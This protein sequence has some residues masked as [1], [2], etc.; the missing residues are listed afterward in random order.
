MTAK[1][2]ELF[3]EYNF[4][5]RYRDIFYEIATG[6][7]NQEI[8]DHLGLSKSTVKSYLSSILK[9]L[10]LNNRCEVIVLFYQLRTGNEIPGTSERVQTLL[11]RVGFNSRESLG[12]R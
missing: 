10:S 6:K 3:V 4:T 2:Y 11:G 8:A 12:G 7:S 9:K 1:L 5:K